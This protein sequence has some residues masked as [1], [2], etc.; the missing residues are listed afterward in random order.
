MFHSVGVNVNSKELRR[1]GD[2][3]YLK[4]HKGDD[5][6]YQKGPETCWHPLLLRWDL[7]TGSQFF[8]ITC[9]TETPMYHKEDK[10]YQD[11]LALFE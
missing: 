7:E 6:V 11:I 2:K 5:T 8:C 3:I 9:F 10:N 4:N 1:A